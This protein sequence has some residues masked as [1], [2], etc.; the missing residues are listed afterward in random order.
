MELLQPYCCEEEEGG[1]E[2]SGIP[3]DVLRECLEDMKAAA[4]DLDMDLME[5]VIEEMGGYGYD[6][7]QKELFDRLKEA[8]NEV[9]VDSCEAILSEWESKWNKN[10]ES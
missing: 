10:I 5:D 2:K 8:V 7:W 9:D 4:E 3:D 6:G 1:E